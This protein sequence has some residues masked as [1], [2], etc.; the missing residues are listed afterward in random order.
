MAG[1]LTSS[2][3][4]VHG[5]LGSGLGGRPSSSADRR[6]RERRQNHNPRPDAQKVADANITRNRRPTSRDIMFGPLLVRRTPQATH[7]AG[8]ASTKGR[9]MESVEIT[10]RKMRP[11]PVGTATAE[12][13]DAWRTSVLT[14]LRRL[15]TIRTANHK[16]ER[17]LQ[18]MALFVEQQIPL[19]TRTKGKNVIV[20]A[21]PFHWCLVTLE[22][23]Q[24]GMKAQLDPADP[25]ISQIDPGLR[26]RIKA[27][28]RLLTV[29]RSFDALVEKL[30]EQLRKGYAQLNR[31]LPPTR[32]VVPSKNSRQRARD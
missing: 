29:P 18:S 4:R 20:N 31:R 25:F 23:R 16:I 14:D 2:W 15:E 17:R 7:R 27:G 12:R 5:S 6:R 21:G 28:W 8:F 30:N 9:I 11:Q 26:K 3:F 13:C 19:M 24:E 1:R 22:Q 10:V 32:R